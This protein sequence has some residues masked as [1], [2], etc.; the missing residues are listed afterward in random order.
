MHRELL[1]QNTATSCVFHIHRQTRRTPE[2][3]RGDT[4]L[5][6]FTALHLLQH[7][8]GAQVRQAVK[9]ALGLF[10]NIG[11]LY[12]FYRGL[13]QLAWLIHSCDIFMNYYWFVLFLMNRLQLS[14]Y[15]VSEHPPEEKWKID[16]SSGIIC[17]KLYSC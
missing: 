3:P 7:C 11:P 15:L 4:F 5:L 13:G 9:A 8:A 17:V 16:E 1:Y 14:S 12:G 10:L 6:F 2:K